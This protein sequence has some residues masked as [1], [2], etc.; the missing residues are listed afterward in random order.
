MMTQVSER[1]ESTYFKISH[2]N[3]DLQ[4]NKLWSI[5]DRRTTADLIEVYKIIHGLLTVMFNTF[6]AFSHNERTRYGLS[7]KLHKNVY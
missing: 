5:K 6:L 2:M 4:K 3:R 1:V 7:L